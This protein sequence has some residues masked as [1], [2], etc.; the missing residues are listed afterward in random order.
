MSR[1][2]HKSN[3]NLY[4]LFKQI[5]E[6]KF[7]YLEYGVKPLRPKAYQ[8]QIY[9]EIWYEHGFRCLQRSWKNHRKTQY[10]NSLA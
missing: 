5:K 9:D 6:S 2:K 10:K 3:N 4:R 8:E 7:E 1:Y